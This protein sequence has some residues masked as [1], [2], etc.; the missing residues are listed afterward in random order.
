MWHLISRR[1]AQAARRQGPL[2]RQSSREPA[3]GDVLPDVDDLALRQGHLHQ[4]PFRHATVLA[5]VG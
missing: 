5:A 3:R 1:R 4:L 2:H